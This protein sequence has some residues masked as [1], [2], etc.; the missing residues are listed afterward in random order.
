M[1]FQIIDTDLAYDGT[2]LSSHFALRTLGIRGDSLIAFRGAMDIP[3]HKIADLEDLR[4]GE[5]IRGARLV[6]F[7]AEHF[8]VNLETAV[9]RQRL[10]VRLAAD[11]INRQADETVVVDGD[12][13]Y[14]GEGKLS[15]SVAAPSPV[16]CLIHFGVNL[17]ADQVP[18]KAAT[19]ADLGVNAD[20]F[21]KDLGQAYVSE[22]ESI[23][24]ALSK[25]RGVP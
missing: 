13:L 24:G 6:H 7:I 19:L 5:T 1:H 21:A 11:V 22:L 18:V 25:V 8:G 23:R 9:L 4:A 20:A 10:L 3:P 16:S 12:D 17:S 2:Q 15:V 14:V